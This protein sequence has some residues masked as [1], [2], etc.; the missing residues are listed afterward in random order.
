MRSH[1]QGY[2]GASRAALGLAL[3]AAGVLTIGAAVAQPV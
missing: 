2:S 1:R 3:V